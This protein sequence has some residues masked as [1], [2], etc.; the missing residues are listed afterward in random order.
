MKVAFLWTNISGYMASCWHAL[1]AV[2][3]VDVSLCAYK[4]T[5]FAPFSEEILAPMSYRLISEHERNTFAVWND[6]VDERDADVYV[7]CGWVNPCFE[8]LA[9]FIKA[10]GAKLVVV[11]DT[12]FEGKLKQYLTRYRYNSMFNA[13]DL[14]VVTGERSYQYAIRLGQKVSVRRGLYGVNYDQLR[15]AYGRRLES[16]WPQA[17]LF[18][19]RYSKEKNLDV[20]LKAYAAYRKGVDSPWSLTCCGTGPLKGLLSD[21]PGV[22]DRGFCPPD[23]VIEEM[24][25]SG[26]FILPSE[27]DPWPLVIVEACASGLP[28]ICSQACGSAVENVRDYY[29]GIHVDTGDVDELTSS[30]LEMHKRHYELPEWGRRS[31]QIA[32]AY[33]STAWA[34][35]WLAWLKQLI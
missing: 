16:G 32:S 30:M 17:F 25:N 6:F 1:D 12:P 9:R 34:E 18:I 11:L 8:K 26:A 4:P 20:L 14:F 29:N 2:P 33:S 15:T 19:G 7:V 10:K 3:G 13:T 5:G 22:I 28:V 23:E 27:F 21:R 35:R 24:S 31:Q